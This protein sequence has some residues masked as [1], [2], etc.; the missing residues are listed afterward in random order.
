MR[1]QRS[2]CSMQDAT[3]GRI[4]HSLV[5]GALLLSAVCRE[6]T[7]PPAP[8]SGGQRLADRYPCDR[9]IAGD[10]AVVWAESFEEGSVSAVTSRY[11]DYKNAGGMALVPDKPSGS[12]GAASL[13]L[14]AGGAASATDL[15]KLLL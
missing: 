4:L 14:T 5:W 7:T 15:Y 6:S 8:P 9:G 12:C 3:R 1:T 11:D 2:D 10:P 13:K